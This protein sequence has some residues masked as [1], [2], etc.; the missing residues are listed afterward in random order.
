[1]ATHFKPLLDLFNE[2]VAVSSE[3]SLGTTRVEASPSTTVQPLTQPSQS[4]VGLGLGLPDSSTSSR[5]G[6]PPMTNGK[7]VCITGESFVT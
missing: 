1:M 6:S 3:A 5:P 7:A 4:S 2:H